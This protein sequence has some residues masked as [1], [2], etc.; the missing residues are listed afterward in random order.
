[1]RVVN[2]SMVCAT[3]ALAAWSGSAA[4]QSTAASPEEV[5]RQF[6]KA[7]DESRWLDAARLLD[8]NRFDAIRRVTVKGVRA[9]RPS[10]R[11]PEEIVQWDPDMPRAVA[12]YQA[13]Q[14]NKAMKGFDVL[15]FQFARVPS[16]D[17]L[18]ALPLVEAAAR[19]LEAKGPKWQE[20][21]DRKQAAVRPA[22][23][24]PGVDSLPAAFTQFKLP[25]AVILGATGG[26]SIRFVVVGTSLGQRQNIAETDLERAPNALTL[27]KVDGA[28]RI[29]PTHDMVGSTGLSGNTTFSVACEVKKPAE[30]SGRKK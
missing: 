28:W 15:A 6:F 11:T 9:F 27:V 5:V 12:E 18:E 23:K 14:A 24:C 10:R 7:E 26:D 22:I 13:N 2:H 25:A 29:V 1:M 16:A 8:L 19:W 20:E 3:M 4:P 17:S 21:R 30:D